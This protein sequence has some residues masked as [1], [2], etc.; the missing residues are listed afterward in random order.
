MTMWSLK[1][2]ICQ[3]PCHASSQQGKFFFVRVIKHINSQAQVT[4]DMWINIC[5]KSSSSRRCSVQRFLIKLRK[6]KAK[7]IFPFLFSSSIHFIRA[8]SQLN[9]QNSW[10]PSNCLNLP[11]FFGRVGQDEAG[12]GMHTCLSRRIAGD[13]T[14]YHFR[15]PGNYLVCQMPIRDRIREHQFW[16]EH[17]ILRAT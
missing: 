3:Y 16:I 8:M 1:R 14:K 5:P 15:K 2:T 17:R 13:C 9:W 4:H 12:K 10:A 6:R 7:K 11:P